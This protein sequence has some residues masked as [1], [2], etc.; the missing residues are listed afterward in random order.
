MDIKMVAPRKGSTPNSLGELGLLATKYR[1]SLNPRVLLLV[2][3]CPTGL[4]IP[5]K[6]TAV[7][8]LG[9]LGIQQF[10]NRKFF[11]LTIAY[12]SYCDILV[13]FSHEGYQGLPHTHKCGSTFYTL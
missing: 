11:M 9:Y 2:S 12:L 13:V 4:W 7:S 3:K 1:C 5:I 6:P 8:G 10:A